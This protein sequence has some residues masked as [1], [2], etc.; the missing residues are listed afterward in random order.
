MMTQTVG[1]AFYSSIISMSR[2]G[3]F[4]IPLLL[5]FTLVCGFGLVGV[6]VALPVADMMAFF[7]TLPLSIRVFKGLKE[8]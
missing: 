4:L 2:Q 7:L 5:I 6:Q 8:E 3:L 1:K